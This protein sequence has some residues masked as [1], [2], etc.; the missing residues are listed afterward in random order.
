MD[1]M[2]PFEVASGCDVAK[3]RKQ[4]S[5]LT[6]SGGID[7]RILAQ[8]KEAV[9]QHLDYIVPTLRKRGGYIPSATTAFLLRIT[10]IIDSAVLS[11]ECNN[12]LD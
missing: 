12:L 2:S 1:V 7:K 8:G 5:E 6:M 11:L 9:D 3:I 4:Y 10:Y